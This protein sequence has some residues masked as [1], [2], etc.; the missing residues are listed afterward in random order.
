MKWQNT[1][2]EIQK[3]I[4]SKM[5]NVQQMCKVYVC[6]IHIHLHTDGLNQGEGIAV[7]K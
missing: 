6:I 7:Y 3:K 5:V 4:I 2:H 1:Y